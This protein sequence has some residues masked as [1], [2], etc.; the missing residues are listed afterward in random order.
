MPFRTNSRP[1]AL[2]GNPRAS[3]ASR[4]SWIVGAT[5]V[6]SSRSKI[7]KTCLSNPPRESPNSFVMSKMSKS[8]AATS[9][10][11]ASPLNAARIAAHGRLDSGMVR[12]ASIKAS[13]PRFP[14]MR[15]D[16]GVAKSTAEAK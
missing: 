5:P 9:S 7:W 10:S 11:I 15:V 8:V 4:K 6:S 16:G 1:S 12:G 14:P 13:A 3:H 2:A